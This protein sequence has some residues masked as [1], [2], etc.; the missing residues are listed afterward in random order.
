MSS[1][2][3]R[4]CAPSTSLTCSSRLSLRT[5]GRVRR[6]FLGVAG[7]PRPLPSRARRDR[8]QATGVEV[9]EITPDSPAERAG[10]RVEDLIVELAGT[11]VQGVDDIQRLMVADLIGASVA[12]VVL[13]H[14][15]QLSNQDT[16]AALGVNEAAASM[17]Y[18]RAVR[19]L[20]AALLPGG[21]PPE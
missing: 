17:R 9:I 13:R 11:R 6:A 20:R 7:G 3:G 8:D 15:E 10:L 19:R 12:I 21:R 2:F 16:A 14:G 5:H 4:Q 1:R 18:L